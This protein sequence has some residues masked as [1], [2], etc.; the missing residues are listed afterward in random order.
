IFARCLMGI[1]AAFGFL[2]LLIISTQWVPMKYMGILSGSTQILG[3][4][5]PILSGG[6]LLFFVNSLDSWRLVILIS[7]ILGIF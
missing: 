5:G 1:G 7:A 3:T 4:L 6:P 2:G